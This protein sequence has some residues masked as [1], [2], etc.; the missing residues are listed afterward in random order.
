MPSYLEFTG[1]GL[2]TPKQVHISKLLHDYDH[3]LS[4]RR[5]PTSDPAYN[6]ETPFGIFE[7]G[8]HSSQRPWA[9]FV[10]ESMV[11]ERLLAR[12]IEADMR[13]NGVDQKMTKMLAIQAANARSVEQRERERM[14]ERTEEMIGIAKL[15]E[16]TSD[17]IH[18]INGE[19]YRIGDK[20][21]RVG[22]PTVL[23]L[24]GRR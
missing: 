7:E 13:R 22:G 11:D 12:V 14:D 20:M 1:Y 21:R 3:H 10:S 5:V 6:P 17:V 24:G 9:F 16:R 19:K 15:G 8:I 18:T 2:N 23:D 4:L